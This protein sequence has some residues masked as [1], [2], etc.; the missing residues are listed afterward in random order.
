MIENFLTPRLTGRRFDD[1][2]I[3]LEFLRDLS[4]LEEMITE[5]AKWKYLEDHEER[6][7]TPRSFTNGIE[8]KLTGIEDGSVRPVISLIL[9]GASLFA[10][11]NQLYFESARDAIIHAIGA[12]ERNE[13]FKNFL[14]EKALSY[15]DRFGR[16]LQ[17]G[18]AIEF[19]D[20]SSSTTARLTK[21]TRR[22]L[23]LS[24]SSVNELS[25]ETFVRGV[26]P[27]IDQQ[28]LSFHIQPAYGKRIKAPL[29]PQ[30]DDVILKASNGYK[31]RVL[32]LVQGIG[33]FDR[34]ERLKEFESVEHVSIL[35]PLDVSARLDELRILRDGWLEGFGKKLDSNGLDWLSLQFEQQFPDDVQLPYLFPTE[36]GNISAEWSLE[37]NEI[38]LEI[39]LVSHTASW[40][41]LNLESQHEQVLQFNLDDVTDWE[42]LVTKLRQLQENNA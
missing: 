33:K 12:A 8:L 39:N 30:H 36:Q 5:V 2:S 7:R 17:D 40:H 35:D 13:P 37:T 27:E 14:P 11:E 32:V 1:H 26:I 20:Q 31:D 15:F 19:I 38:T 23:V 34:Q 41:L 18:E 6:Q 10:P 22:K 24:S 28:K 4:V 42:N 21:E 3:P 25:E 9:A 16:S 29:S